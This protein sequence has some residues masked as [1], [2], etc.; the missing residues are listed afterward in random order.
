MNT[1]RKKR[2]MRKSKKY[3]TRLQQVQLEHTPEKYMARKPYNWKKEWGPFIKFDADWDG[4]YLLDLI[5][6]KLEKMYIGLDMYS[7][8]VR[9]DLDKRLAILKKTI[10]LGKYIQTHDYDK[11]F[12]E[13]SREHCAHV[14]HIYLKDRTA[15]S[16]PIHEIVKDRTNKENP[17][18]DFFC[19]KQIKQWCLDNNYDRKDVSVAY[20]GRWDKEENATIYKDKVKKAAKEEQKDIDNF[21]KLIAKNYRGW[22]W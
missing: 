16:Q 9:E 7:D 14:V 5:I 22:W 17:L 3:W 4:S 1:K 10:D 8:E 11:E 12:H 21:F 6:Y 19:E 20:S 15:D 2:T 18:E 13:W